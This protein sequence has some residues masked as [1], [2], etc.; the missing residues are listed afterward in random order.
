MCK[1]QLELK[2]N[3]D[4]RIFINFW[5]SMCGKDV[6]TEFKDDKLY[7]MLENSDDY[8]D[9]ITLKQFIDKVKTNFTQSNDYYN[10]LTKK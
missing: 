2:V 8:C 3:D 7:Q 1:I 4:G 9:E 6:T 5:D 10:Q